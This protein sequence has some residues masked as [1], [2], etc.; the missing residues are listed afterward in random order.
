MTKM[1][2]LTFYDP[3]LPCKQIVSHFSKKKNNFVFDSWIFSIFEQLL[4][5]AIFFFFFFFNK[6]TLVIV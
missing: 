5:Q 3:T 4:R 6:K 1:I 2:F